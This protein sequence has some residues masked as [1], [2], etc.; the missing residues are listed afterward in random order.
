MLST[1]MYGVKWLP[2]VKEA[3]ALSSTYGFKNDAFKFEIYRSPTY[4]ASTTAVIKLFSYETEME[5][6]ISGVYMMR[7]PYVAPSAS[8]LLYKYSPFTL[9]VRQEH[10]TVSA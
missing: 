8:N 4:C 2:A 5:P 3:D 1:R 6:V 9:I 7:L 10:K